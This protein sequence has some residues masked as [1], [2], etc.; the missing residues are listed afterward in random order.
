[1]VGLLL[2]IVERSKRLACLVRPAAFTWT[3]HGYTYL[4]LEVSLRKGPL[5]RAAC[6]HRRVHLTLRINVHH[7]SLYADRWRQLLLNVETRGLGWR[8]HVTRH[9]SPLEGRALHVERAWPI[10]LHQVLPSL[11]TSI[12]RLQARIPG[13]CG[14]KITELLVRKVLFELIRPFIVPPTAKLLRVGMLVPAAA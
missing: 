7:D 13:F 8:E 10:G 9:R 1:M 5:Q 12:D 4:F 14:P 11:S 2:V 6:L 3:I